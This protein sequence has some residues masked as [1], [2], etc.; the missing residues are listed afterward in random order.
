M[1]SR[2]IWIVGGLAAAALAFWLIAWPYFARRNEQPG[3]GKQPVLAKEPATKPILAGQT[4]AGSLAPAGDLTGAGALPEQPAGESIDFPPDPPRLAKHYQAK[5][6]P[7]THQTTARR[8]SRRQE[9]IAAAIRV[10]E[11]NEGFEPQ[12]YRDSLGILTIGTGL[13]INNPRS[14]AH[15]ELAPYAAGT[16]THITPKESRRLVILIVN[17]LYDQV[18]ALLPNWNELTIQQQGALLDMA[19]Q[20]GV[21]GLSRF[22]K[23]LGL[24]AARRWKEAAGEAKRSRW[25]EQTPERAERIA[26]MLETRPAPLELDITEGTRT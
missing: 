21:A 15:P 22:R 18:A 16:K 8:G 1:D 12:P 5:E 20:L 9:A 11:A 17:G 25:N 2:P 26:A 10:I 13:K 24:L 14:L 3:Q 4:P 19:Y 23:M 7:M 6:K